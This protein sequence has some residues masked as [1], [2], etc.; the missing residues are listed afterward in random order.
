M[1]ASPI[2]TDEQSPSQAQTFGDAERSDIS[3]FRT[4]TRRAA[5][6]YNAKIALTLLH[7]LI[8][9]NPWFSRMLFRLRNRLR[10]RSPH[11]GT[12]SATHPET[13]CERS[14]GPLLS[15]LIPVYN[16][17]IPVLKA[18]LDSVMKQVYENWELCVVDDASPDPNVWRTLEDYAKREKRIRLFR[19]PE[20]GGIAATINRAAAMA[21]GEYVG[22]LDHDDM[23]A[24]S[25][26]LEFVDIA[27]QHPDADLIY[28]DEDKIDDA[29]RH[30][31][32]WFK[33]DWNPDLVLSFNYVMHFAMY[34]RSLFEAVGG[35]RREYEGSQDYDLLL[36]ATE[37]TERIYHIPKILYHWRMGPGSIASGPAAKPAIFARGLAALNAALER[38]GIDGMAE[39]APNAWQ[40]VWR[41]RRTIAEP[42]FCSVLAIARRGGAVTRRLLD[43]LV[44]S[45][46]P[47]DCEIL[48]MPLPG[49]ALPKRIPANARLVEPLRGTEHLSDPGAFNLLADAANGDLLLFLDDTMA[50]IRRESYRALVEQAQRASIGA[51]GGKILYANGLVESA[52][53][54]FGP[55]GA[56]GYAHRATPDNPG[57]AG[58]KAMIGNYS[59]VMGLGMMTR[60][61]TFQEN[62][63]FDERFAEAL[64]DADYCLR[65]GE[66]GS[67]ITYTPYAEWIHHVP[68]QPVERLFHE[69]ESLLF[70]ERWCKVI[71][72]DPFFNPNFS[73]ELEDFTVA[74]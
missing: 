48:L 30:V 54:V 8:P 60:T 19:S 4:A 18:C 2:S 73:R 47:G 70:R 68:I 32:P 12:L 23:L 51:V 35:V 62:G 20:N 6:V 34:R 58:L 38:R 64:W 41:V 24:P 43:S 59:A 7:S 33:S 66:R 3:E 69:Q 28:C 52:G 17:D 27:N 1:P 29:G 10:T 71:D 13:E 14:I 9:Q 25:A 65:L 53:V 5:L 16:T 45:F 31:D 63:G 49:A 15:V 21:T 37:R 57:Y 46:P 36:R 39:Q 50:A 74:P 26:L 56:M 44:G 55:Y 40:G 61:E 67:R 11:L 42:R 22:V 72:N